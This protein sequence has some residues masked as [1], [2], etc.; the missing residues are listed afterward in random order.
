MEVGNERMRHSPF[1]GRLLLCVFVP[2][3]AAGLCAGWVLK[4]SVPGIH[5]SVEVSGVQRPVRIQRDDDGVPSITAATDHDAFFALGYVHAQDRMWQMDYRRR[6]GRGRLSEVLG[7]RALQSDKLM[8][9]LGL[10]HAARQALTHLT[11]VERAGLRAYAAGVNA[12][13][14]GNHEL[15]V[16]YRY[17]GTRPERWEESD[18][19]LMVKLLALSLGGNYRQELANQVLVMHLGAERASELTG[20]DLREPATAV[21][22]AGDPGQWL[23]VAMQRG[24]PAADPLDGLWQTTGRLERDAGLGGKGVGSNAWAVAGSYTEGGMP[25]LAGDPHLRRQLPT[26]FYLAKLKGDRIDVVGAT[27]PGV[28]VVVF[29]RNAKIAWAATNLAADAQDLYAERLSLDKE[30]YEADGRWVPIASRDEWIHVAAEFPAALRERYPPIRWRVR[31]TRNGPLVS[32]AVA[33]EGRALAL[34]WTALDPDDRSYGGILAINYAEDL[35]AFRHA[36]RDY[37]APALNFVYA[38]RSGD[39]AMLAAGRIPVRNAGDGLLPAPGWNDSHRWLRYLDAAELPAQINPGSGRVVSANQR[40]HDADYPWLI[41]NSWQS[42]YRAR[43]IEALLA[44]H[45]S[46]GRKL[47]A[48]DMSA[49]QMDVMETQAAEALPLLAHAVAHTPLQKD[50]LKRLHD[51]DRRMSEDSVGA[52]LYHVWSRH[53]MLRMTEAPLR[54]DLVHSERLAILK[55]QRETFRP[56]LVRRIA[57]GELQHWCGGSQQ[58]CADMA[59][60]ALDD[61]AV[62]LRRLRGGD[63]DDWTWGE[64]HQVKLPHAPFDQ[65]PL[66]GRLFDRRI[67]S[68]GGRYTINVSVADYDDEHGYDGV[69]GATYR[70]VIPLGD[71]AAS[72]F[73]LDSGQS[74]NIVDRH[75]A[76]LAQR[77]R[78]GQGVSIDATAAGGGTDSALVLRP[79]STASKGAAH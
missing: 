38:D 24:D 4:R 53:L 70:Q 26:T 58:R 59:L 18:S 49:M 57:G 35:P 10:E 44:S 2:L 36:L 14:A 34:R 20:L 1:V 66:L 63:V 31:S 61:A 64:V 67:P 17:F 9:T 78:T 25:M 73:S 15:P 30:Q 62:E 16:E 77:H 54:L 3:L 7:E 71:P 60:A 6:L 65:L 43:R 41:S 29:G 27:L 23:S 68:A 51:W 39:I 56:E 5:G 28:P 42:D 76:D 50:L 79:Q 74:G 48:G 11:D 12:W 52:A 37:A 69:L 21:T 8:R 22:D 33:A 32:D 75:Y 45:T 40:I 72:L 19:L 55:E 47:T 13:I 46:D